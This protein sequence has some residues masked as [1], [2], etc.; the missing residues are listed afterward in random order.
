MLQVD[1]GLV[2]ELAPDETLSIENASEKWIRTNLTTK[3][4]SIA[5]V[6]LQLGS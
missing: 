6:V 3:L 2:F 5:Y 1:T 4:T